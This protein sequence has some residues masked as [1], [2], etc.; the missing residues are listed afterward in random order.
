MW[1]AHSDIYN[2]FPM[3]KTRWISISFY[4]PTNWESSGVGMGPV[5]LG[6]KARLASRIAGHFQIQM[7]A[8]SWEIHHRWSPVENPSPDD[9]PSWQHMYY[10]G[11]Y[12]NSKTWPQGLV[13]FSTSTSQAALG[14]VKKGGWTDWILQVRNDHRSSAGGGTGFLTVWKREDSG[15]WI[16]VLHVVPKLTTREGNT[17]DH[18]IGYNLPP[19]STSNGG[20]GLNIGLYMDKDQVWNNKYDRVIY[21]G[22]FKVG[23]E[24]AT[25]SDMSHDGSSPDDTQPMPPRLS[26]PQ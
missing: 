26:P 10:S 9:L 11:S 4:V 19:S 13:D 25:F 18:G 2:A 1:S 15:P 3:Q 12:P 23:D 17:F 22:N 20:Y 5:L 24:K 6:S 7:G 14:S 21:V 16:K 8:N